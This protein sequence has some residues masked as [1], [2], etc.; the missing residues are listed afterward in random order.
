[1]RA[2]GS[3]L[4]LLLG[5]ACTHVQSSAYATRRALPPASAA[6]RISATRDPAQAEELGVVEA[7]AGMRVASLDEVIAEF[8]G[9]VAAMGGDYGRIDTVATKHEMFDE[10]YT[11]E[12]GSTQTTIETTTVSQVNADGSVSSTTQSVPLTTYVSQTCTGVRQV[13]ASTLSVVGRAFR[14]GERR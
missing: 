14:T 5:L 13:E 8:R 11:Y 7:H 2:A 6:V 3:S 4:L 9:R 1:M 12:C 10:T